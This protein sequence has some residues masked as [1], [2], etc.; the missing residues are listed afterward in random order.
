MMKKGH[1]KCDKQDKGLATI[2]LL[3]AIFNLMEALI[4]IIKLLL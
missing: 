2:L 3:T 1:K 4:E